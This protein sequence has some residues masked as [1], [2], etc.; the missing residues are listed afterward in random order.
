MNKWIKVESDFLSNALFSEMLKDCC[1]VSGEVPINSKKS[2][3]HS[4][5]Q[6][7]NNHMVICWESE[8]YYG[9]V[10]MGNCTVKTNWYED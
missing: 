9:E 10:E 1:S 7:D 8:D 3:V 2:R 6:I 5:T 4:F